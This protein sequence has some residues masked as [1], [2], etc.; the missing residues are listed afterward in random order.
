MRLLFLLVLTGCLSAPAPAQALDGGSDTDGD[1]S[2]GSDDSG[3]GDP[4]GDGGPSQ[5]AAVGSP[6]LG[7]YSITWTIFNGD[8]PDVGIA[9]DRVDIGAGSIGYW[10][11]GCPAVELEG[12]AAT[13]VEVD[14]FNAPSGIALEN[15]AQ[16][17]YDL[18]TGHSLYF[19]EVN[20]F[21][22]AV[23]AVE[24]R[25]VSNNAYICTVEYQIDGVKL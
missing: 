16:N 22:A 3:A 6:H 4:S 17:T 11:V 7:T 2:P 14:Q 12:E 25:Q 24:R 18:L 15:C 10:S 9:A 8:C 23:W 1:G 5:D 20:T 19:D 21:Y 13:W